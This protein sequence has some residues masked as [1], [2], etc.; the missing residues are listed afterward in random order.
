MLITASMPLRIG[1]N[2]QQRSEISRAFKNLVHQ[3]NLI[4][5][6]FKMLE[7]RLCTLRFRWKIGIKETKAN[8]PFD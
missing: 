3:S 4:I 1:Q 7:D 6:D 8:E 2:Y 5:I